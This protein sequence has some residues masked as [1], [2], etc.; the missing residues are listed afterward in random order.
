MFLTILHVFPCLS[1]YIPMNCHDIMN[2]PWNS[3]ELASWSRRFICRRVLSP[4]LQPLGPFGQAGNVR[5]MPEA[6]PSGCP[7]TSD[8][9][10]YIHIYIYIPKF[11]IF[12]N[13]ALLVFF[14]LRNRISKLRLGRPFI[15]SR[16]WHWRQT[17]QTS[18]R[19]TAQVS[20]SPVH[21]E[22]LS[23]HCKTTRSWHLYHLSCTTIMNDY[24]GINI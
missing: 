10:I 15:S 18:K 24:D 6:R 23:G 17:L 9:Y 16:S 19:S 7:K 4:F 14:C 22:H 5:F 12:S 21:P 20:Q 8:I 3:T 1:L 11:L 2:Q 13:M